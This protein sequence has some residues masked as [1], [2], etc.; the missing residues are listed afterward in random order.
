MPEQ[1]NGARS[2]AAHPQHSRPHPGSPGSQPGPGTEQQIVSQGPETEQ[3]IV[4]QGP[5]TE[6][7]TVSQFWGLKDR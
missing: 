6:Q 1:R 5:E 7:Q 4:S 3:Q 2:C